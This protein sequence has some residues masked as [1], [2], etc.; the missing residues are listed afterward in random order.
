[1]SDHTYQP[2]DLVE[3]ISTGEIASFEAVATHLPE[4]FG[5]TIPVRHSSVGLSILTYWPSSDCRPAVDHAAELA[6]K[7]AEIARL[8][9]IISKTMNVLGMDLKVYKRS[10]YPCEESDIPT[11]V[12]RLAE[13]RLDAQIE[14]RNKDSRIAALTAT[15]NGLSGD[16]M[17]PYLLGVEHGKDAMR[18]EVAK[19]EEQVADMN[20]RFC[21]GPEYEHLG[22]PYSRR[23][24]EEEVTKLRK[25]CGMS[26]PW[27]LH[28]TVAKLV[29]ATK[30]F[31]H[32][33]NS[34]IQGWEEWHCA[35][36]YGEEYAKKLRSAAE[37]G[38]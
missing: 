11:N 34:D 37:G 15:I 28:D 26:L 17:T 2:G 12:G 29:E 9:D 38:E 8:K 25:L 20:Q 24:L 35:A 19:L 16:L 18:G 10:G 33:H 36:Q 4:R 6:A 14:S 1:M 30:A 27:P 13:E 7:D 21:D 3:R 31:L 32:K 23:M 22:K 5:D